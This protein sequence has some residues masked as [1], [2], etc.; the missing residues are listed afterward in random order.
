MTGNPT[1]A[2]PDAFSQEYDEALSLCGLVD[3]VRAPE[4]LQPRPYRFA[5]GEII[6]KPGDPADCLWIIV[7]GAIAVKHKDQTVFTRGR[8]EVVGEQ[9][10]VGNGYQRTYSLVASESTV[11]VLIVDKRRIEAHPEACLL[12]RNIAKI[13]SI[14]LRGA[15]LKTASLARQLAD[16]TRILHAYTNQ[17]ALSRRMQSGGA[18]QTDYKVE[19]CVI[20]FSDVVNFSQYTLKATPE[21]VADIVQRFFNAQSGP[22]LSAGGHIDKFIGDGLMAFW[23][24]PSEDA[25]AAEQCGAALE[26][27]Q[28]AALSVSEIQIGQIALSLRI[29]LHIGPVVSGDFGSA[30]RHQFTLIGPEVNKAARLEQVH[31][32]DVIE[33]QGTLGEIRLSREFWQELSVSQQ[34]ACPNRFVARAKNI[35]PTDIQTN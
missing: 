32:D 9:H 10:L 20:W 2:R 11:E 22:I 31:S 13:I 14:K 30:T 29:G 24:L 33:G 28:Q 5:E 35:G 17:Y 4:L 15:S 1:A 19:R 12:W 7:N 6:C 8:N 16:D 23:I 25:S 34:A 27:A 21:R 3:D 18:N 26:A